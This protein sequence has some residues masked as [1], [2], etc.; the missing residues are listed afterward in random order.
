MLPVYKRRCIAIQTQSKACPRVSG[1]CVTNQHFGWHLRHTCG[2]HR[3]KRYHSRSCGG[4]IGWPRLTAG[5][6]SVTR[7]QLNAASVYADDASVS[8]FPICSS[9]SQMPPAGMEVESMS[10]TASQSEHAVPQ[11]DGAFVS[12]LA[13]TPWVNELRRKDGVVVVFSSE[14]DPAALHS[15]CELSPDHLVRLHIR[16]RTW[17]TYCVLYA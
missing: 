17:R 7:R 9:L 8:I 10:F 1:W 2:L 6:V 3:T 16:H 4:C 14:G 12:E 11:H 5:C 15:H 13:R